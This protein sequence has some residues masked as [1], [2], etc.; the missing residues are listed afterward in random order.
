MSDS[1]KR[2]AAAAA[3][4][5]VRPGMRLGIGTGSTAEAFIRLL[6][7]KVA[8][9]MKITGVTTSRRSEELCRQS[10]VLTVTLDEMPELDLT[11]DGADEIG[12]DLALIKGG[13]AA[14]LREKIVAG[15]SARM[16][17]IADASKV[18]RQLGAF[19]LPVEINRFGRVATLRAIV[20]AAS[21]LGLAGPVA[22]RENSGEPVVTDEGHLIADASF[23]RIPDPKA[24]SRALL[25]IPGVVQHGLFLEMATLAI[26]A[27][28][29]G[30][31]E[32]HRR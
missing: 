21:A 23:G 1:L 6:A 24:L 22:I 30:V 10:G 16:I 28:A 2:A 26:V 7:E 27:G 18:V 15:A 29:D 17:V 13:G 3:L 14:L 12:P 32:L 20:R 5:H 25:D 8:G 4:G 31:R 11:V 19:P 9:G